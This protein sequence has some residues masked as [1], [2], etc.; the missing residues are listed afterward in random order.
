MFLLVYHQGL[1]L[2]SLL[3]VLQD[4]GDALIYYYQKAISK[5]GDKILFT[6]GFDNKTEDIKVVK[7]LT[8]DKIIDWFKNEMPKRK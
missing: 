3:E 5:E 6:S 8:D 2:Y 4:D 7:F 1:H